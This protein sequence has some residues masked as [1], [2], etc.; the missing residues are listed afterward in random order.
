MIHLI[1]KY[2]QI[3]LNLEEVNLV[4]KVFVKNMKVVN[5]EVEL[6]KYMIFIGP[7]N[8]FVSVDALIFKID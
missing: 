3:I 2:V 5:F 7:P 6:C 4:L 1:L 8:F